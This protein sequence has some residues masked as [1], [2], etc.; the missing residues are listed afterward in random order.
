MKTNLFT[1][2]E[3]LVIRFVLELNLVDFR[4][5]YPQAQND[6]SIKETINKVKLI[7]EKIDNYITGKAKEK[8][9]S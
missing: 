4:Y 3:L 2:E 1:D 9:E 6:D 8:E 7:I 5:R